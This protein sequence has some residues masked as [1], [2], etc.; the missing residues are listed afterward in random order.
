[1]LMSSEDIKEQ[2]AGPQREKDRLSFLNPVE[3]WIHLLEFL[4]LPLAY[5]IMGKV[6]R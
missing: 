4:E 1:M 5:Y 3:I 2:V 6:R